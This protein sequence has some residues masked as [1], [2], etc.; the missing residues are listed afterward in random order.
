MIDG[1]PDRVS[2]AYSI[3]V[4]IFPRFAYSLRYIA[5]P[6]P[7]GVAIS[8]VIKIMSNVFRIFP[9]IP[10]VPLSTLVTD[11][12]KAKFTLPIPFINT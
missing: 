10:T 2:V 11:V 3:I 1:I 12:R 4:T 7:I 9:A 6:T 5:L 8:I